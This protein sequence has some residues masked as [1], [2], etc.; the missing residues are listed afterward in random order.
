MSVI[1]MVRMQGDAKAFEEHAAGDPDGMRA[2]VDQAKE[3]GLIA[4]RFYASDDGQIAAF[5]EWPDAES[6][7]AFFEQAGDE[8]GAMMGAAGITSPPQISHWRKLES[9]D[10]FGWGA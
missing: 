6:F 5:D 3:H 1:V 2:I 9:R 8:I 10:D 7:G 4:H